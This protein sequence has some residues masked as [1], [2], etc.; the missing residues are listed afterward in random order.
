M[1]VVLEMALVAVEPTISLNF[2]G[3]LSYAWGKKNMNV[4]V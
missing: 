1:R 3:E 2:Q 4:S